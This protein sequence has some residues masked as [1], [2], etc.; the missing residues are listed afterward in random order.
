M[1]DNIFS[2]KLEKLEDFKFDKK[3][4]DVFADMIERSVPIYARILQFLPLFLDKYLEDTQVAIKAN[5]LVKIDKKR[6]ALKKLSLRFYDLGASLGAASFVLADYLKNFSKDVNAEFFLVDNS[7]SMLDKAQENLA[8]IAKNI[9]FNFLLEDIK[10][11]QIENADFIMLNFTLQFLKTDQRL[12]LLEKIYR[13]LKPDAYFIISEK[14]HFNAKTQDFLQDMHWRFKK[15][16]GYSQT[17]ISQKR[18]ALENVLV[19]ETLEEHQARLK[20]AGFSKVFLWKQEFNFVS[21]V[22]IK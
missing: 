18:K 15:F 7:R 6:P 22:A 3:V 17:E 5:K 4:A 19:T 2:Q 11:I 13:G 12:T 8:N 21:L 14:I 9:N 10:D 16:N 1:K 20:S